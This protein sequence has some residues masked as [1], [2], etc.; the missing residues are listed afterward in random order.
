MSGEKKIDA[1]VLFIL[2]LSTNIFKLLI[3][4]LSGFFKNLRRKIFHFLNQ[5]PIPIL[6]TGFWK[7]EDCYNNS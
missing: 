4:Y 5:D 2:L 6:G 1:W 7:S 3:E